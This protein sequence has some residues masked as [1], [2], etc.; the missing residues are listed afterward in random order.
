MNLKLPGRIRHYGSENCSCGSKTTYT[1][2]GGSSEYVL[3][4]ANPGTPRPLHPHIP[5]GTPR[6]PIPPGTPRPL[7]TYMYICIYVYNIQQCARDTYK[8]FKMNYILEL[9]LPLTLKGMQPPDR[10]L[11]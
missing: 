6:P 10:A 4:H 8:P 7:H 9:N 2:L 3:S 11:T 5:P 1:Q